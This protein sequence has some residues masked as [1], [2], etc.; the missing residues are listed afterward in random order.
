MTAVDELIAT[1]PKQRKLVWEFFEKTGYGLPD[2]LSVSYETNT[3]LTRG[4]GKYQLIDHEI[5]HLAGPDW[6]PSER[7]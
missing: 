5:I 6:D 2:L 4:G 3:F 1:T 7:M